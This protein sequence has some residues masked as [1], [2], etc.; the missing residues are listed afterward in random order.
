MTSSDFNY[1][2]LLAEYRMIWNNRL[3][4]AGDRSSEDTL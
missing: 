3:L 2:E 4:A 1:D